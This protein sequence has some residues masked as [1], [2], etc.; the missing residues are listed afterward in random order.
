MQIA[1]KQIKNA[2][3]DGA[4]L[5]TGSV[6]TT[7]IANDAVTNAKIAAN[8]VTEAKIAA[9]AVTTD[10][11]AAGAVVT[12]KLANDAVT[13]AILADDSV[14]TAKIADNAVTNAR[15]ADN[16]VDTLQIADDAVTSAKLANGSIT[17]LKIANGAVNGSKLKADG[18]YD[19]SAGSVTVATP[20][21]AGHAATKAYLDSA[22][23]GL[24]PK[25]SVVVATNAALTAAYSA[26]SVLT[27]SGSQAAIQ[28]DGISLS[29]NDRVLVKDQAAG[30]QNG[31]YTV[32]T[33]GS[34][35]ANWVLTRS[36]DMAAGSDPKGAYVFAERGTSADKGFVLNLSDNGASIAATAGNNGTVQVNLFSAA[37]QI[38]GGSGISVTGTTIDVDL[39]S[40]N[41]NLYIDSAKLKTLTESIQ[42]S[43]A[44]ATT[45]ATKK[46]AATGVALSNEHIAASGRNTTSQPLQVFLNGVRQRIQLGTGSAIGSAVSDYQA[47]APIGFVA[48]G[49][50]LPDDGSALRQNYG[51]IEAT[52]K[53]VWNSESTEAGFE[54][55]TNDTL[56]IVTFN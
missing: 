3:L 21:Q 52:D 13:S 4:K 56:T 30:I 55:D 19:F 11:I 53:I 38:T 47:A 17:M 50:S 12:A 29:L 15:L 33:V 36:A 9:N 22:I 6:T 2:T 42:N 25:E 26:N 16:A 54:L 48:A 27:N 34:G 32:T 51:A 8:A 31:I 20:T 23:Q 1:G 10:K 14:T 24:D 35:T 43:A 5:V 37:G 49:T 45:A 28:I 39:T 41:N 7:K 44:S 18:D 46:Y 40:S